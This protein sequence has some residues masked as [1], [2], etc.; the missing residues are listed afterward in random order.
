MYA[1]DPDPSPQA[2]TQEIF[3]EA[4]ERAFCH[5][6]GY[7]RFKSAAKVNWC[8]HTLLGQCCPHLITADQDCHIP[9]GLWDHPRIYSDHKGHPVIIVQPYASPEEYVKIAASA[10]HF[11]S[12]W[13]LYFRISNEESWWNPGRTTLIEFWG[14]WAA[15]S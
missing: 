3:N 9:R 13:N 6:H 11:A 2:N 10:A 4:V 8:A 14:K 15:G 7:M 1:D 12:Q 5:R